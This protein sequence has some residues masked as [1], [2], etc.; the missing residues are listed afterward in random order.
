MNTLPPAEVK[1]LASSILKIGQ[2][3]SVSNNIFIPVLQ[4]FDVLIEGGL[5]EKLASSGSVDV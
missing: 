2:T 5:I 3:N 1:T 4:T